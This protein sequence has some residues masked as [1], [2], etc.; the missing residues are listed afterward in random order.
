MKLHE[1]TRTLFLRTNFVRLLNHEVPRAASFSMANFAAAV[2]FAPAD[3]GAHDVFEPPVGATLRAPF[4]A[5]HGETRWRYEA[6]P[7]AWARAKR[8]KGSLWALNFWRRKRGLPAPSLGEEA[9]L[10]SF[11]AR[12]KASASRRSPAAHRLTVAGAGQG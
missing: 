2:G 3:R 1:V 6:N 5:V 9:R 8:G 11:R 10:G 7:I 4:N 12:P